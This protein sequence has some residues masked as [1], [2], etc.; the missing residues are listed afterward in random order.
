[1]SQFNLLPW[2]EQQR[3]QRMRN[4][5]IGACL[6]LTITVTVVYCTDLWW[7]EWLTQYR[8]KESQVQQ[9]VSDLN[10]ELKDKPLWT[11]RERQVQQV[12]TEWQSRLQQQSRAW[13]VLQQLLSVPARGVQIERVLWRDQ[14]LQLNG[15]TLSAGH[16]QAWLSGL[17]LAGFS[18]QSDK[19]NWEEPNWRQALGLAAKQHRFHLQIGMSAMGAD[20]P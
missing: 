3:E 2:R 8:A 12:Q 18:V 17:A 5:R 6:F 16:G 4:W 13:Q 20:K 10:T 7:D 15:W 14:Q 1:M 19:A 9:K 11:A